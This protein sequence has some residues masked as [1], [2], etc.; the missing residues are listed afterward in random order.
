[1]PVVIDMSFGRMA[2]IE[3]EVAARRPEVAARRPEVAARRPQAQ[4]APFCPFR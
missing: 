1:M 4:C 2:N 3:L